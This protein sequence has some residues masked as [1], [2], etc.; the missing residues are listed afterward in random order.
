MSRTKSINTAPNSHTAV[1]VREAADSDRQA[2]STLAQLDSARVPAEPLIVAEVGG[3]LRAAVSIEDGSVI[4]DPFHH[5]AELVALAELR[6]AH[7][8]ARRE[9]SLRVVARTA[10]P[11]PALRERAA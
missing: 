3:E 6:A 11:Q 9:R 5:T 4:A 1:V 10:E 8:R 7:V 2:L